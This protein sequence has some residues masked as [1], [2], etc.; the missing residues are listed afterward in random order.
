MRNP[1][2]SLSARSISIIYTIGAILALAVCT[3]RLL[4]V[5]IFK[6]TSNDECA[7]LPI[8]GKNGLLNLISPISSH[9]HDSTRSSMFSN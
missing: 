9:Y 5:M 7:W 4:D 3:V 1:F 8:Q 2:N 6:V